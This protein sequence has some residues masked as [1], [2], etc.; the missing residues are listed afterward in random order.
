MMCERCSH[1]Q[2]CC[3]DSTEGC[4]SQPGKSRK[5]RH[6]I[7]NALSQVGSRTLR[8]SKRQFQR[9]L[10]LA[11]GPNGLQYFPGIRLQRSIWLEYP[12]AR[13]TEMRGIADVKELRPE[14]Q[15]I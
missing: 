2:L 5:Q 3:Q 13:H 10:N 6:P 4:Y 14:R 7:L 1:A 8:Y 9:K 11:R 12:L 15:A